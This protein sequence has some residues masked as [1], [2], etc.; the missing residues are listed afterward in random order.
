MSVSLSTLL[1]PY[2]SIIYVLHSALYRSVGALDELL[3]RCP[4]LRHSYDETAAGVLTGPAVAVPNARVEVDRVAGIEPVDVR[5]DDK[6]DLATD[7]IEEFRSGMLVQ[8][9]PISSD[10][11]ELGQICVESALVRRKIQT[12]KV[13]GNLFAAGPLGKANAILFAHNTCLTPPKCVGFCFNYAT[14][15]GIFM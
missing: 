1:F 10:R 8:P 5:A 13:V 4:A 12:L 3:N 11:L 15:S 2:F 14:Y 9:L 7:Q 6:V